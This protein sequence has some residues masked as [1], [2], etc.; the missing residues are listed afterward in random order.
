MRAVFFGTPEFA[1]P[2][3]QVLA[4]VHEVALAVTQPD[5][6]KGRGRRPQAPPVK[7]LAA[8][9]GIPVA[10][11]ERLDEPAVRPVLEAA[12]AEIGVV[13]AYGLRLPD[14]LLAFFP[15]G[16]VNVHGS[17]LPLLRGAAPI[18]RAVMEGHAESGVTTMLVVAE[19]DAGPVL[20]QRATPI[21]P[22]ETS[23]EL[24]ARL[25]VLGAE[26]LVETLAGLADGTVA[27]R[28]Q[29]ASRAT[30]AP[31]L[32]KEESRVDWSLPARDLTARI[33]GLTPWPGAW[34]G[35]AGRK[36]RILRA[37]PL[38]CGRPPEPPGTVLAADAKSGLL[39]A[40]ADDTVALLELQWEGKR[41]LPAAEFLRGSPLR[42]GERLG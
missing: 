36:L 3:L 23:G 31:K 41:A 39:V 19:M 8:A 25:A 13:V 16:M 22:A 10:Q 38:E 21:G 34:T 29:D 6:P 14:W 28:E 2:S 27:P 11:P 12:G 35:A 5:R 37:S 7:E 40:A 20:L 26:L 24:A 9:L 42:A 30:R 18:Q 32:R 1:V 33:R 17:L 15:R 4:A